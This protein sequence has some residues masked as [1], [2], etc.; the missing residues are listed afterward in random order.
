VPYLRSG[1]VVADAT[2]VDGFDAVVEAFLGVL[3]GDNVGKMIVR[4]AAE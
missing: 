1:G 3:R 4:T 2:L